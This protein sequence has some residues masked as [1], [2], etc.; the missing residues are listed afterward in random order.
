LRSRQTRSRVRRV[1]RGRS[2]KW[3]PRLLFRRG[4]SARSAV[5][6]SIGLV[7]SAARRAADLEPATMDDGY[8]S[9]SLASRPVQSRAQQRC[10]GDGVAGGE[11]GE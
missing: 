2:C 3:R 8:R 9:P 6:R 7:A 11:G 5:R 1:C 4:G 10:G